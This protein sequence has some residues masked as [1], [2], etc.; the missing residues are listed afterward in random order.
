MVTLYKSWHI[1][2][3]F[4]V[5]SEVQCPGVV[6]LID[7]PDWTIRYLRGGSCITCVSVYLGVANNVHLPDKTN[8]P[9]YLGW[10]EWFYQQPPI[11]ACI[12]PRL[13]SPN[14][15]KMSTS[16]PLH[17]ITR[18]HLSGLNTQYISN[19]RTLDS[20]LVAYHRGSMTETKLGQFHETKGLR[21]SDLKWG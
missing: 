7:V 10:Y 14:E 6:K 19:E 12:C 15:K 1:L 18:A 16:M 21:R 4:T 5:Q 8:I 9:F 2:I 20:C 17:S 11:M 3:C 13:P